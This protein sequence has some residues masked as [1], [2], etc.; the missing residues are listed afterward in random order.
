MKGKLNAKNHSMNPIKKSRFSNN[1][2]TINGMLKYSAMY[3]I[4]IRVCVTNLIFNFHV[5]LHIPVMIE[6]GFQS[7]S[8]YFSK[9][10]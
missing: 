7:S 4:F 5:L 3:Y 6:K 10:D 8:N 9:F 2:L 1:E